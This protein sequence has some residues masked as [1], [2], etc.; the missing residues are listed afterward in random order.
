[1]EYSGLNAAQA[2]AVKS[3]HP[4]ILCLAGAG[5]GKTRV[6][7][8][9]IARL[10]EEGVWPEQMLAL[11]FTRAAGAEM[12]ERVI[13][14]I[15]NDGREV[16]CNTFHAWAVR[17]IR[18][19]AYR[20]GYTPDF[21]IYDGED[22]ASIIEQIINDLQYKVEPKKVLDAMEKNE[23]Y[24]VPILPGEME[25]IV[26]EYSFRCRK[27]NAIDLNGLISATEKLLQD[28]D[29][30]NAVRE[31]WPYI[32]V[33]EFQDT[34]HRQMNI[35]EAIKPQNLFVVGDD[36]QSI[37]GF[38]GADVSIIMQLAE[39]PEY[40][41]VK[42]EENYRSTAPIVDA[43]NRLIKHNN[44]TEKILRNDREGP[45]IT[46]SDFIDQ[47]EELGYVASM[48][49]RLKEKRKLSYK[50][51]AI[52]GRTNKQIQEA[53]EALTAAGIPNV[54]R[55]KSADCMESQE[56]KKLFAWMDA[57]LNPQ[58]DAT[59]EAV[60]NW[61]VSTLK[62]QERLEAE[63]FMYTND[64]SLKTALEATET[65]LPFLQLYTSIKEVIWE[66][67]DEDEQVSAVDLFEIVLANTGI[68]EA[69]SDRGL[70]N[71][72]QT[73]H[74]ISNTIRKWQEH[75]VKIGEPFTAAA[76][77][78]RYRL[79]MLE[80]DRQEEN[81]EDAVQIM[82]AHGSKGLEFESVIIIGCNEKSFP[83]GKGDIEEERR[84]FYVAMTRAKKHLYLTRALSKPSWGEKQ[85]ETEESRFI[86][87]ALPKK[88]H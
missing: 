38:R 87:E 34:D 33:D 71:R 2:A 50:D 44:Q 51:I 86:E 81:H 69:Y 70:T 45:E 22:R 76:W 47:E 63:Q 6:L 54:I 52:L 60:L 14:L 12:K 40:Q 25:A 5:T 9:R 23:V 61:P 82:T 29:V 39:D 11:T 65:A 1:M 49:G 79:R 19:Y 84:L 36:F 48:I 31:R 66:T 21:T 3:D 75:Q 77:L 67:Y 10:Y 57:I 83:L 56:A 80:T 58:N 88:Y 4:R 13:Q 24:R 72:I 73:I 8:H 32:F 55:T 59:I 53:A 64:C 26:K 41:V 18:R 68:I 37:Y 43:A 27:N 15:G 28:T 35:I 42:L 85:I 74:E 78:E 62:P 16:F 20:L 46:I 17:L 30:Q 7:T